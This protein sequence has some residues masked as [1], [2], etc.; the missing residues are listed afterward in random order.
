MPKITYN[1][2]LDTL[3]DIKTQV[4]DENAVNFSAGGRLASSSGSFMHFLS[5]TRFQIAQ[6]TLNR[7]DL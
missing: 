2:N 1:S 4:K 7:N 5:T 6:Q 3:L